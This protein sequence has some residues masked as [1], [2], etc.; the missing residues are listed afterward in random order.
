MALAQTPLDDGNG[1]CPPDAP[2][3]SIGS[4]TVCDMPCIGTIGD[5]CP[6]GYSCH[7]GSTGGRKIEPILNASLP[8]I[9]TSEPLSSE[10]S[11]LIPEDTGGAGGTFPM[12]PDLSES[13]TSRLSAS[14]S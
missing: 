5:C 8:S 14:S 7:T 10:F 3:T 9:P 13:S 4:L 6:Y 11:F 12:S 2:Y 1:C